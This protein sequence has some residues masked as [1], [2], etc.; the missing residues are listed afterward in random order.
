[1]RT[2]AIV[3]VYSSIAFV[4]V[5]IA[6]MLVHWRRFAGETDRYRA[7]QSVFGRAAKGVLIAAGVAVAVLTGALGALSSMP[8]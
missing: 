6:I 5:L 8:G 2:L 7:W 3:L 4:L 1:M